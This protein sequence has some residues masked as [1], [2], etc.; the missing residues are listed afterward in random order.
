MS[1][2]FA[3][4]IA[5]GKDVFLLFDRITT[6]A[7]PKVFT[8]FRACLFDFHV[9]VTVSYDLYLIA[10]FGEHGKLFVFSRSSFLLVITW[11]G[12]AA[13]DKPPRFCAFDVRRISHTI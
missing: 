6:V 12:L 5:C 8:P 3:R 2:I 1:P 11:E 13:I 10:F 9:G 7:S 4:P